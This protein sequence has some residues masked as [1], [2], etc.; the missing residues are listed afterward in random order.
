MSVMNTW[1]MSFILTEGV[2]EIVRKHNFL[3][4]AGDFNTQLGKDDVPFTYNKKTNRNGT[5]LL[6]FCQEFN[7]LTSNTN[8]MKN[9]KQFWTH[10]LPSGSRSQ[11]DYILVAKSGKIAF[12]TRNRTLL[13]LQ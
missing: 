13:F 5:K 4:I 2:T 12:V 8:F 7:L 1:L 11:I 6:E 9:S 3:V 10:Q